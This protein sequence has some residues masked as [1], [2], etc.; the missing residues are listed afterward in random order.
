MGVLANFM[1]AWHRL[2]SFGKSKPQLRKRPHQAGLW[3]RMWCVSQLVID[4]QTQLKVG[5]ATTVRKQVEQ[6]RSKLL[7]CLGSCWRLSDGLW[8]GS[9]RWQISCPGSQVFLSQQWK[10]VWNPNWDS[11]RFLWSNLKWI[12]IKLC[13]LYNSSHVVKYYKG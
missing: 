2:E 12:S 11:S 10:M 3:A 13:M 5:S 9:R 4:A 1:P 8:C 7:P 6:G